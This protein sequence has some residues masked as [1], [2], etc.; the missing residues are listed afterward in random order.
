VVTN[1]LNNAVD[2]I[3]QDGNIRIRLIPDGNE[4]CLLQI[5]DDGPGM[6]EHTRK[7][8]FSPFFTTKTADKGTGL[9]LYIVKNI[10]HNH[11]AQISCESKINEGATFSIKFKKMIDEG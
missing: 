2:A 11:D 6:D 8:I 7:Q 3:G 1:L 5:D 9:G 10:C 4:H